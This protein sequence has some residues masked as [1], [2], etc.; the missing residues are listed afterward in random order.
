[1]LR[2]S[3]TAVAR[4]LARA[5]LVALWGCLSKEERLEAFEAALSDSANRAW[6]RPWVAQRLVSAGGGWRL[7]KLLELPRQ[8]LAMRAT[9][10]SIDSPDAIERLLRALL[11]GPWITVQRDFFERLGIPNDGGFLTPNP[12]GSL[13]LASAERIATVVPMI[14]SAH[15]DRALI[16]LCALGLLEGDRWE[17][18]ADALASVLA[19][20]G[21]IGEG[22]T[23]EL[24]AVSAESARSDSSPSPASRSPASPP[25]APRDDQDLSGL[26]LM[27]ILSVINGAGDVH[28]HPNLDAL[29]SI[30][31]E[32]AHLSSLRHPSWYVVGYRDALA[33]DA[34]RTQLDAENESRRRW[35]VA[36]YV[37]GLV[38]AQRFDE[39]RE[40]VRTQPTMASL[41]RWHHGGERRLGEGIALAFAG[42]RDLDD[43]VRFVTPALA[44]QSRVVYLT[45]RSM[46]RDAL[47]ERRLPE[48]LRLLEVA[49]AARADAGS[50][51]TDDGL[52]QELLEIQ[53]HI[54]HCHRL[55]GSFEL[56]RETIERLLP[57]V[58]EIDPVRASMLRVDLGLMAAS[59]HELADLS[60]PVAR[61]DFGQRARDLGPAEPLWRQALGTDESTTYGHAHYA[62]GFLHLV[63]DEFGLARAHLGKAVS[64]FTQLPAVYARRSILRD[65]KA[66]L[67]LATCLHYDSMTAVEAGARDLIEAV[68]SG[69]H[70]PTGLASDLLDVFDGINLEVEQLFLDSLLRRY[71]R[72]RLLEF[73]ASGALRRSRALRQA[74]CERALDEGEPIAIRAR[75]AYAV[76]PELLSCGERDDA[77]AIIDVLLSAAL[78]G[79]EVD[80]FLTLTERPGALSPAVDQQWDTDWMR[81]QVMRSTGH[82]DEA[83]VLLSQAFHRALARGGNHGFAD[84]AE[85]AEVCE[86]IVGPQH[87]VCLDCRSRLA[88]IAPEEPETDAKPVAP[89]RVLFVGGNEVQEQYD[90]SLRREL[91]A[92]FPWLSVSFYHTNW[93]QQWNLQVDDVKRR[94]PQVD[95]LVISRFVRT[96]FGA[97]VRA[98]CDGRPWRLCGGTG[99]G[100]MRRSILL[101][102]AMAARQAERRTA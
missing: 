9:K 12:D 3:L 97:H 53:R 100:S 50:D 36:G 102:A 8:E 27:M 30:L 2:E 51:G 68:E 82:A 69:F 75:A 34:V 72:E 42:L 78:D 44:A 15:G 96:T 90:E 19:P 28:G 61:V 16:Y 17:S 26:D 91:S 65:A 95:A 71:R 55:M 66:H 20:S 52:D 4:D 37:D 47:E 11:L 6:T 63:R 84:A 89:V 73:D 70:I 38:R 62:L 93:K 57:D 18:V 60:L 85:I 67:A 74:F 99:K 40:L 86:Q 25:F 88:A 45:V 98:A 58:D 49:L 7:S 1:M 33:R 29:K 59:L 35:Y 80:H 77:M 87:A 48:C 31:D 43:L 21:S 22:V 41:G 83:V 39:V 13:P 76:L 79:I 64:A 81:A 92:Q 5:T 101:V 24:G 14:V 32:Y 94:L 10:L 46:G 56:A 23:K 54:A